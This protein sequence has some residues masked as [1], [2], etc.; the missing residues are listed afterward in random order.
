MDDNIYCD[1]GMFCTKQGALRTNGVETLWKSALKFRNKDSNIGGDK[2]VMLS[3]LAAW[4]FNQPLI[5]QWDPDYC[6]QARF[7]L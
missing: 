2:F 5:M 1:A 7:W 4:Y 6:V 3:N